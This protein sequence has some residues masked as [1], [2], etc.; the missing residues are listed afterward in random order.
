MPN[1]RIWAEYG[2]FRFRPIWGQQKSDFSQIVPETSNG[3]FCVSYADWGLTCKFKLNTAILDFDGFEVSKTPIFHNSSRR[4]Q[5]VQI[6]A[7]Y[8][9]FW[10]WLIWGHQKSNFS[11]LGPENSNGAFCVSY[12]ES[13]LTCKFQLNTA[14]LDLGRFEVSK[15]PI[16]HKSSRKRQMVRFLLITLRAA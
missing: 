7:Q 10:F 16:F 3:A 8:G 2:N 15:I 14:M 11:Q 13:S 4:P 12:V 6:W 5:M 9:E 1:L